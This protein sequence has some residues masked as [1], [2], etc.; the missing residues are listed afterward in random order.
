MYNTFSKTK[1]KKRNIVISAVT[2]LIALVIFTF[3]MTNSISYIFPKEITYNQFSENVDKAV[4]IQPDFIDDS[5]AI[6]VKGKSERIVSKSYVAYDYD[7]DMYYGIIFPKTLIDTIETEIDNFYSD[8]TNEYTQNLPKVYGVVKELEGDAKKFFKQ[9]L[10]EILAVEITY[11]M[12]D[13][14]GIDIND[15]SDN[16]FEEIFNEIKKDIKSDDLVNEF[17]DFYYIEYQ[18]RLGLLFQPIMYIVAI[19]GLLVLVISQILG[20]NSYV[21][22]EKM[23][24]KIEANPNITEEDLKEDFKNAKNIKKVWVGKKF[25]FFENEDCANFQILDEIVWAFGFS[26]PEKRGKYTSI[27]HKLLTLDKNGEEN[28]IEIAKKDLKPILEEIVNICPNAYVGYNEELRQLIN[29]DI[30]NIE[31]DKTLLSP[32]EI[33][34]FK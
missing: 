5:Y 8:E 9:S 17:T 32:F 34:N 3:F 26:M 15:V 19:L 2:I 7:E 31:F 18:S 21:K 6:K 4:S 28:I 27:V 33:V 16:E 14:A 20:Y 22:F 25:I 1:R 30:N 11:G 10:E 12:L 29:N 23:K 13:E 24:S